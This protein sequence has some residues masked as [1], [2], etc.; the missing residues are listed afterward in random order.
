[1]QLCHCDSTPYEP[2]FAGAEHLRMP[3]ACTQLEVNL[4]PYDAQVRNA[5]A[6]AQLADRSSSAV[7]E[8]PAMTKVDYPAETRSSAV[9][10]R[11]L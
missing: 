11:V 9:A 2:V 8:S 1:M 3:D 5:E 10:R 6:R 4:R 7:Q